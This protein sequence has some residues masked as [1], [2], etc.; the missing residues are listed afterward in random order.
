MDGLLDRTLGSDPVHQGSSTS[1]LDLPADE[2]ADQFM[3]ARDGPAS[4][5]PRT[6]MH[7]AVRQ[8]DQTPATDEAD[9]PTTD[10]GAAAGGRAIPH[11]RG[12][13][14][15]TFEKPAFMVCC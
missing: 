3:A 9:D 8:C 11:A 2:R 1:R 4:P 12:G 6:C 15:R 10:A 7:Q 13:A 14:R 5:V